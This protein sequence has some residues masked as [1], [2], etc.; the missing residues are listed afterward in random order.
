MNTLN[1]A[2]LVEVQ[3]WRYA[4]KMF[5][6]GQSIPK[7]TWK[8]IETSLLL[9]PS[10]YGLQPWKFVVV[11]STEVK[12]QLR[13]HSW[14]QSQ[15]EDCS[16]YLVICAKEKMDEAHVASFIDSTA[17]TRGM[18]RTLLAGYEKMMIG[19]VVKG[20]RGQA[21]FEWA[22]R[23][24]YIALGNFMT[25][26]AL[27]GVDTCPIEGFVPPEYD[28]VL[29]LEG[30]GYKSVVCCAAGYRN[31]DDKYALAK[32]VRFEARELIINL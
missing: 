11:T 2:N 21:S 16:H 31:A 25:S 19:D 6:N 15:V 20:P 24:C 8:A 28:K 1:P 30:T 13:P 4:T 29:K 10:S 3:N 14:N 22:A 23:Q 7:D 18:D 26:C 27:V 17:K 12:K 9:S 5:K 32:K